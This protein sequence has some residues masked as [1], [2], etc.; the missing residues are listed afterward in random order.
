MAPITGMYVPIADGELGFD[1]AVSSGVD[2]SYGTGA[3]VGWIVGVG[4]KVSI[5]A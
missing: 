1:V 2:E 4:V 5:G 3:K